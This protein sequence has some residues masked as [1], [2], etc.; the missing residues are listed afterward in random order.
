MFF[1]HWYWSSGKH[2]WSEIMTVLVELCIARLQ[3]NILKL[4]VML[5]Q[6]KIKKI[7]S[8]TQLFETKVLKAF[9]LPLILCLTLWF[10]LGLIRLS[11]TNWKPL[12]RE[13]RWRKNGSVKWSIYASLDVGQLLFI[14]R[15]FSDWQNYV[16]IN[17]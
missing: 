2:L 1:V 14:I 12:K 7:H 11:S 10:C 4:I 8:K 15:Y 5:K 6:T 3:R 13:F 16:K 9:K 17:L